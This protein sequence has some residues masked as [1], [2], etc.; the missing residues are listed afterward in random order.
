MV[1]YLLS[2]FLIGF[3]GLVSLRDTSR[4]KAS[5][6]KQVE[7]PA[8]SLLIPARD[9]RENITNTLH[10]A[11]A[12]DYPRLEIIV[13]DDNS[14]DNTTERIRSF[15][16]DGVRFIKGSPTPEHW[17]GKNWAL[18]QL[19]DAASGSVLVFCDTNVILR[20]RSFNRIIHALATNEAK[21]AS[22]VPKLTYESSRDF[23]AFPLL[24][25]LIR[26][27]IFKPHA[28][29][30]GGLLAMQKTSYQKHGGYR[31][32]KGEV[33]AELK[34]ARDYTRIHSY[35]LIKST[36]DGALVLKNFNDLIQARIRYLYPLY[37]R[38]SLLGGLHALL[39]LLPFIVIYFTPWLY[40][41]LLIVFMFAVRDLTQKPFMIALMLPLVSLI[42]IGMIPVSFM[43][44]R[45]GEVKWKDR[46]I[47]S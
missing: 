35:R 2:T 43:Q 15:A 13:L 44:Y 10:Q 34:I 6:R 38:F 30:Y 17:V 23:I 36:Q 45:R 28:G 24:H 41:L 33:L 31:R 11:L 8:V 47:I 12:L 27:A 14:S 16:Q 25:W 9:E 29:A 46:D 37:T 4:P 3:L 32:Y 39:S 26:L 21:T 22:M 19:A 5:T 42:D 7:P 40:P 1:I 18:H 20:S